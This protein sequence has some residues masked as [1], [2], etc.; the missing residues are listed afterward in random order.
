M[1]GHFQYIYILAWWL[2]LSHHHNGRTKGQAHLACKRD[3]RDKSWINFLR[4]DFAR[5]SLLPCEITISKDF[6]IIGVP[7]STSFYV[8]K[9]IEELKQCWDKREKNNPCLI[10]VDLCGMRLW[11]WCLSIQNWS[12]KN[13]CLI[14]PARAVFSY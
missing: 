8:E 2:P 1:P 6:C 9:E 11:C 14:R 3:S 10:L 5:E 13:A 7:H 4:Y 12:P